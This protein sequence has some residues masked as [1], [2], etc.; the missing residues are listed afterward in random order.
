MKPNGDHTIVKKKEKCIF[1]KV[2]GSLYGCPA[3]AK[4][5]Y[6][7]LKD[8]LALVGFTPLKCEPCTFVRTVEGQVE[9]LG[10]HVGG[11]LLGS[12]SGARLGQGTTSLRSEYFGGEG[13]V[14]GGT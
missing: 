5:W 7:Y 8:K 12:E 11:L 2:T 4:V 3:A 6:D 13:T 10:V 14:E 9:L 1:V